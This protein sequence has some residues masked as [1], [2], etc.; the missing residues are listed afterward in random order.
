MTS[1][2]HGI[3]PGIVAGLLLLVATDAGAGERLKLTDASFLEVDSGIKSAQGRPN[4]QSRLAGHKAYLRQDYGAAISQFER[5]AYYADKFSQ[6]SLSLMYWHG[7]GVTPDPVQAYIWADLAAERGSKSLLL[8]RERMWADLVPP[9]QE[10]AKAKGL[11]FYARYSDDVAQPR[12]EGAMRRF[13]DEMTGSRVG[14]DGHILDIVGA[15]MGGTYG[16]QVGSMASTYQN[17]QVA[18]REQLY[19]GDRRDM[20]AYWAGQTRLLD[21]KVNVGPLSPVR[22][23]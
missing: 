2:G 5:A 3:F 19:G 11:A 8:I 9:R 22:G 15:P 16:P 20:V 13:A 21:G 4:E 23:P 1:Q 10:Q 17:A 18:S 7:V 14:Y 6:H 12:A